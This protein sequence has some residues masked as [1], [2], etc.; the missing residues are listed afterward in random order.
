MDNLN[1]TLLD[2]VYCSLLDAGFTPGEAYDAT[3]GV[4][5]AALIEGDSL[6]TED[7]VNDEGP[8]W[9]VF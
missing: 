8:I 7:V 3:F 1:E 5:A 4:G 6:N 9:G 2:S